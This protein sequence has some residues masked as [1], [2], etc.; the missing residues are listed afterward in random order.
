[1]ALFLRTYGF[2]RGAT[3]FCC[4]S[5]ALLLLSERV[6]CGEADAPGTVAFRKLRFSGLLCEQPRFT[7]LY[8]QLPFPG[9]NSLLLVTMV[10]ALASST[11][12]SPK[13]GVFCCSCSTM[14]NRANTQALVS[15]LQKL[16]TSLRNPSYLIFGPVWQWAFSSLCL[17]YAV[18]PPGGKHKS[19]WR[20]S[21]L[22]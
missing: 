13:L 15:R 5:G 10:R 3:L 6:W 9:S 21:D 18:V 1:M 12:P 22:W 7:P 20:E 11:T 16:L 17:L 8:C 2:L 14:Q 19:N 4:L